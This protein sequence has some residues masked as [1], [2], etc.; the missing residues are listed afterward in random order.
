MERINEH[1]RLE[2]ES[3]RQKEETQS[4]GIKSSEHSRCGDWYWASDTESEREISSDLYCM[5]WFDIEQ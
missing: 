1:L 2:K 5:S 3:K 4:E